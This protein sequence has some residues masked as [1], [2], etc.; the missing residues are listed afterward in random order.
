MISN[1]VK[2][3]IGINTVSRIVETS[4]ECGWQEY[5]L[6]NDDAIDGII[7]MRRGSLRPADTGGVVFVQVKC[8]GNGYRSDQKQYPNHLC[9]SLGE[10]YLKNHFPRWMRLP[11]PVVLIYIDDTINKLNPSSWWVDLRSD[12][13]SPT[14]N[15]II[16]IPR[17]QRFE[18]HTKGIFH[19]MCG[20]GPIDRRLETIKLS[21][22][23]LLP[24]NLGK[25]ESLRN[26]AWEFYKGWRGDSKSCT[27]KD[28][29]KIL[30]NRVGWK[31]ITR[32]ARSKH[33]II[34]SWLLLG[35]AKEMVC[36]GANYFYLGHSK[37]D[38][39]GSG[40]TK[41]VDY[42]GLKANIVFPHRHQSVVQVV[43]K[44]ERIFDTLYGAT[45]TQKIWF[46]SVFEPRRGMIIN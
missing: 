19:K 29:G 7:L 36:Q 12:C 14:N 30:V 39:M 41:I 9:I 31:H 33:R 2:E 10:L 32:P 20:P 16:L 17:T 46:Y 34:Q 13:R 11:G 6:Q 42:L 40:A 21:K 23:Q 28:L 44:R 35:A 8:G 22:D 5:G 1:R 18:H 38:K 27:H 26:D 45:V 15:G 37:I 4:W 25:N 24:I 43:L 3:R